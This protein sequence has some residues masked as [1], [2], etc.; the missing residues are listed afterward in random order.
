[1]ALLAS[2]KPAPARPG[3]PGQPRVPV[4]KALA[5]LAMTTLGFVFAVPFLW[6]L[7]TSLKTLPESVNFSLL[8]SDPT[9]DGYREALTTFNFGRYMLNSLLLSTIITAST[10]LL[11]SLGGYAF[12][13]LRFPGREGL[14][15]L[16]L[17][18]IMVPD[19]LRFVPIYTMLSS[20]GLVSTFP[21]YIVINL[22]QASS[23][24]LMRQYFL[25]IPR[26]FEEAAKL[27]GAGYLT[28]FRHIMLPLATPA[29]AAVAILTFQGTWNEF[30][31]SVVLLQD[32]NLYTIPMGVSSFVQ[33][34]QTN[35]PPLMAASVLALLPVLVLYIFFQR[36]FISGVTAAGVKG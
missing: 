16:V 13:R 34:Y 21:G 4:G 3:V 26:D 17:G 27:D 29:L 32:P 28:T 24:F 15:I 10:L 30:F 6:S 18:T 8:P 5:Y 33:Q 14:F 35:W 20:W 19:Q 12:A 1:M 25:T 31:W 7:S 9:L 22:V 11:A 2:P 23:L 36:Y